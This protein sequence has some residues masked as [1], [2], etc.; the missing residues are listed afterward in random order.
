[1]GDGP[2]DAAARYSGCA[3]FN[4]PSRWLDAFGLPGRNA[5]IKNHSHPQ[6]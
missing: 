1:V 3:A 2:S 4:V 5:A 6:K